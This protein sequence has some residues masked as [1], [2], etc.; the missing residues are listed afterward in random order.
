M[1]HL[2]NAYKFI[3]GL[4]RHL[5][6]VA[7]VR[8]HFSF[9][10]AVQKL[11]PWT[12]VFHY[13]RTWRDSKSVRFGLDFWP[14]WTVYLWTI[15]CILPGRFRSDFW[16]HVSS[17]WWKPAWSRAVNPCAGLSQ[18]RNQNLE[19]ASHPHPKIDDTWSLQN[20]LRR[21]W[22]SRIW[23]KVAV[24]SATEQ[25]G[26]G[27]QGRLFFSQHRLNWC[28]CVCSRVS[29]ELTLWN[30][31]FFFVID[32]ENSRRGFDLLLFSKNSFSNLKVFFSVLSKCTRLLGIVK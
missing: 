12:C 20:M 28:W 30:Y 21:C 1:C 2:V 8:L 27:L 25:W 6:C 26:V 4:C 16:Y 3:S 31:F 15:Y 32:G 29:S 5:D 7:G 23:R 19:C 24:V 14:D 9:G 17:P 22:Q 13:W 18:G 10:K 11:I